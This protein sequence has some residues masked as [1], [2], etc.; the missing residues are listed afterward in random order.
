MLLV[1]SIKNTIEDVITGIQRE[2]RKTQGLILTEADLKCLIYSKLRSRL[3][4]RFNEQS[5]INLTNKTDSRARANTPV[6]YWRMKTYD[7]SVYATPVHAE[8]AWYDENHRLAIKPD[9]TILDPT[10]LS[11]LHGFGSPT[12]PS[13]QYA[14]YGKA[15]LLELKFIRNK[16]GINVKTFNNSILGDFDKIKRLNDKLCAQGNNNSIFCYFVIFDKTGIACDEFISFV[17]QHTDVTWYKVIYAPGNV[18]FR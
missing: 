18:T 14:F 2:Y 8:L 5:I 7:D 3:L 13:K 12:L 6:Y 9:I 15:I 1:S 4:P 11:I 10:N 17:N 16:T